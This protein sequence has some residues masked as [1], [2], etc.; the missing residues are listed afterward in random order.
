MVRE[1]LTQCLAKLPEGTAP[2]LAMLVWVIL[3]TANDVAAVVVKTTH[4]R[5]VQPEHRGDT[6]GTEHRIV[7]KTG[8]EIIGQ[9]VLDVTNY[10]IPLIVGFA[11]K[12][13]VMHV[14]AAC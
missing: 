13:Q 9:S 3:E 6:P 7:R 11:G 4:I 8:A 2:R 10:R 14:L 1:V 12:Q 5:L